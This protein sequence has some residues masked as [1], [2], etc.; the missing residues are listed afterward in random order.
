MKLLIL[1]AILTAAAPAFAQNESFT[2]GTLDFFGRNNLDADRLRTA[3]PLRVGD[4]GVSGT[5]EKIV[6]EVTQAIKQKTGR[7]VTDVAPVCCDDRRVGGPL[8]ELHSYYDL[9]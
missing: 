2:V 5:K 3:L 4:Q 1:I 8:I 7:D 6:A 9:L